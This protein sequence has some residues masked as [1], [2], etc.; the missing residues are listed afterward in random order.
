MEAR[1]MRAIGSFDGLAIDAPE[2]VQDVRVPVPSLRPRDV[3]VSVQ[4]VSVNPAD[5]KTRASLSASREPRI[6]GFDAAGVVEAV[7]TEVTS[8]AVGDEVWYAG[9]ITRAGSN[10]DF[11]AV[12][13]R[14]VGHKPASLSFAHA[15]ALPLTTITAGET[16]FDHFL[17]TEASRG[18]LLI[19][20]G[21]GG[22]GSILIQLAKQLTGLR[23]LASAG[24]SASAAWVRELGADAVVDH[25]DLVATTKR[26]A[27]EGVDY[28]FSPHSRGNIGAY[29]TLLRPFGHVT[30]I[31]EPEGLD[32]LPLKLKSIAWH[33]ELMF[34][35]A[36][37]ETSDMDA[38]KRLLDRVAALVDD[39][40]IRT[41]ATTVIRDFSATGLR[42]AHRQVESGHTVGKVVV[43]R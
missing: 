13:E 2:S 30:A 26:E 35:R 20:G 11:Q 5:V 33:W 24:R 15:A 42:E 6:L 3:L 22:V 17:L 39:K 10:A 34:T 9:D 7:G 31:D 23:V 25:H 12:D 8:L 28:V 18:T 14:L 27:P 37:F 19:M 38:Q 43:T 1:V 40:R 36:M 32:L 29:A 16:L 4:A 21:A 41:T